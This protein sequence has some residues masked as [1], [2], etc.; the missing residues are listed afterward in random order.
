MNIEK[1]LK[2]INVPI[3]LHQEC[4]TYIESCVEA[5]HQRRYYQRRGN[6]GYGPAMNLVEFRLANKPLYTS[7]ASTISP[8]TSRWLTS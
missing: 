6:V 2:K 4:I 3:E 7:N 8:P 1:L 5:D